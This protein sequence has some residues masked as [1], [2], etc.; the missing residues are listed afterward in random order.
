MPVHVE[1]L[2]FHPVRAR[3]HHIFIP[4]ELFDLNNCIFTL[5]LFYGTVIPRLKGTV[6]RLF[7]ERPILFPRRSFLLIT[8]L[9]ICREEVPVRRQ[10]DT[11]NG[12]EID[13]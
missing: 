10:S 12:N 8:S 11:V 9:I 6:L 4:I 5:V 7:Q 3:F 13:G 1:L 2:P